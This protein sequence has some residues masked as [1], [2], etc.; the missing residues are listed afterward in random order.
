MQVSGKSL[1]IIP[2][3]H[4][5]ATADGKVSGKVHFILA[6][7]GLQCLAKI[8]FLEILVPQNSAIASGFALIFM[9]ELLGHVSVMK[10]MQWSNVQVTNLF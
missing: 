10:A 9:L 3:T 5:K 6:I 7:S 4:V 2:Y 8:P 1:H